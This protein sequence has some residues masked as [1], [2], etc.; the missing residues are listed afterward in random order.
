[1]FNLFAF[2]EFRRLGHQKQICCGSILNRLVLHLTN[3]IKALKDDSVPDW[4]QR[5]TTILPR[6]VT[7]MV[8]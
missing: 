5:A 2:L 8:A 1:L 3:D 7:A 4:G 6:W